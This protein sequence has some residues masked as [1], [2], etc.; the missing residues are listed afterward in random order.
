MQQHAIR[1]SFNLLVI[2]VVADHHA[3]VAQVVAQGV[4]DLIIKERQQLGAAVDQIHLA[5]HVAE[6]TGVFAADHPGA[7]NG[8]RTGRR[9]HAENGV[10]IE[11]AGVVK[12]NV[13]GPERV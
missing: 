11:N 7:A 6:D 4:G 5:A 13:A 8:D 1:Q 3:L 10:A 12:I 2:F 9:G